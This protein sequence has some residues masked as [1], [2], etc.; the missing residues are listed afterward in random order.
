MIHHVLS[1][2]LSWG[3]WPREIPPPPLVMLQARSYR[4]HRAT[5]TLYI[6]LKPFDFAQV[7]HGNKICSKLAL[8]RKHESDIRI[9]I[10]STPLHIELK[11]EWNV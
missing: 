2:L 11:V 5:Q 4:A 7:C 10:P 3:G 1:M 9:V 8:T 6:V